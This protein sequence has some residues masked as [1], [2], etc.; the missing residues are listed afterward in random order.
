MTDVPFLPSLHE[1]ADLALFLLRVWIA[2]LFGVSGWAHLRNPRER[3]ESIGMP[4]A[5]T[6]AIGAV[7]LAGAILLVVGLW[8]QPAAA[9]LAAIM[10]GAIAKKALVW[11]TGF[12]GAESQGWYY[13]VLYFLCN[14]VILTTGGG[15]IGV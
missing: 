8:V 4:P 1:Y 3:A 10:L 11:K 7:E 2:I 9:A 6:A 15:S 13:E 14:L 5:A 12:W